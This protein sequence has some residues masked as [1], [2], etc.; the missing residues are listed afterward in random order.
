MSFIK[1]FFFLLFLLSQSA[2]SVENINKSLVA[3]YLN[4][5][6]LN[7]ERERTK[8]VDENLV[9]AFSAFKPTIGISAY[10]SD[11]DSSGITTSSGASSA[12]ANSQT[13]AKSI[14]IEQKIF[15]FNDMYNYQK[16]KNSVEIARY[17]LKKVEQDVLLEAVEAYS[18]TLLAQKKVLYSKENLNLS[19]KQADL[20][21]S[22]LERGSITISDLAQTESSLAAAQSNLLNAENELLI[23]KKNFANVVGYDPVDLEEI[24]NLTLVLPQSLEETS[25]SSKKENPIL[26]ISE[27]SLKKADDEYK[28]AL[29]ELGPTFTLSL[30]IT[31]YDG[32]SSSYD[33]TKQSVAKAQASIPLYN[34]GKQSSLISQKRSLLDSA[35]LDLQTSRNIV[36][37][38]SYAAWSNYKLALSNFELTKSRL[39]AS[40]IAYD[41]IEQEYES[42]S[43]STLDVIISRSVLL[44][45]RVN[46][47]IA[48]KDRIVSQF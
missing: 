15:N 35:E 41:G 17:N 16:E 37:R 38:D 23:S 36:D 44:E 34:G 26:K 21:K 48:D 28:V 1:K 2:Y 5:P 11:T 45:S 40:E 7:S 6:K 32:Y 4:N 24:N 14:T 9:Q 20:D 3:A 29:A 22:R 30:G 31:D 43:R 27:F 18:G 47:A 10:K 19:E 25:N 12:P 42:G 46:S 39:Q 8:A 33:K 13:T